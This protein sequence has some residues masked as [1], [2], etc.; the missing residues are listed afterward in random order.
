MRRNYSCFLILAMLS[1]SAP[2]AAGESFQRWVEPSAAFTQVQVQV[3]KGSLTI[4]PSEG[5]QI[6][7]SAR[8]RGKRADREAVHFDVDRRGERFS[9]VAV[10]PGRS[11]PDEP[12][13]RV[14]I[15]IHVLLPAG[16]EFVGQTDVGD[17]EAVGVDGPL[18]LVTSVGD[19]ELETDTYGQARTTNGRIRARIGQVAWTGKLAF[20]TVN[21][22]ITVSLPRSADIELSA[23]SV[24][25]RYSSNLHPVSTRR[26]G[27]GARV[28]GT[29]G[30]GGRR[31]EMRTVNG[32]LV[33]DRL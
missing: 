18:D 16:I 12:D 13:S 11:D 4:V 7:V 6:E 14:Q 19:I 28:E 22:D 5:D 8:L 23:K 24:T 32:D 33:L 1:A 31:L 30:D 25:G 3:K 10:Y 21:G 26:R 15:D 2:V 17:I 27:P 9:V 29:L 20:A